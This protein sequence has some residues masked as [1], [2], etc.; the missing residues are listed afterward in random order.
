MKNELLRFFGHPCLSLKIGVW[1]LGL[2]L[3]VGFSIPGAHAATGDSRISLFAGTSA[4][5]AGDDTT[6]GT[7]VGVGWGLEI[8]EQLLWSISA[9]HTSTDGEREV[10]GQKFP[11][12]AETTNLQTGLTHFFRPGSTIIPFTGG[13]ISVAAYD[14]DYTYPESEIGKTTGTSPG[15]FARLGVEMRFTRNF[16]VIPQYH[17]SVHSIR[18]DQGDSKSL[19]SEG[20]LLSL[21]FST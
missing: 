16:T 2:L 17:F 4:L 7:T 14:V 19:I 18:S 15:L 13:G 11:I 21:R 6:T 9:S 3:V 10:S 1:G 20:L 8:Q 12:A 5:R